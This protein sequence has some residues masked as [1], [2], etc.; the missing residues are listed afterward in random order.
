MAL[1]FIL[2]AP[3]SGRSRSL[4]E[5]CLRRAEEHPEKRYIVLVPEQFTLR[6]QRELVRLSSRGGIL[7]IDV[8]SFTRL[9]YRVF[10]QTGAAR[11]A[12]LSETGKSL[13]LRLIAA[14]EASGLSLLSGVLDRPGV[15]SEVKSILS[16][17][18]QY[19]ISA[20]D[21]D[22]MCAELRKEGGHQGLA[23]KLEEIAKLRRACETY[24]ADRFLTGEMLPRV[25][26]Q[27][28]PLD[29]TLKGCE[30]FLDSYN[31]FTPAQLEVLRVLMTIASRVTVTVTVDVRERAL[32]R[33][34]DVRAY[35]AGEFYD[36]DL[37]AV[38]KRTIRQLLEAADSAGVKTE[39]P[40]ILDDSRGRLKTG[41]AL[42]YLEEN[43]FRPGQ[44]RPFPGHAD[45][46]FLRCCADPFDEVVSAAVTVEELVRQGM[47][48]RDIAVVCGSLKEYAEYAKR[49]FTLYGIPHFIDRSSSALLNPAFEFVES[50]AAV[51]ESGFTYE[52]IMRL[53]RT[54]FAVDNEDGAA[55]VLE[56][57]LI[58]AGIRG[59]RAWQEPFAR[60]TRK[61][62]A[63]LL[64]TAENVRAAFME[65]FEPFADVMKKGKAPVRTYA[66]AV[67]NLLLAF[68]VPQKLSRMSDE[69]GEA[70][71]AVR[72]EEYAQVTGV[73]ASVLD[74]AV[75]LIGEE[76]VTRRQFAD[77]LKAGFAEAKIGVI[78]PGID[79]VHIGDFDRSRLD[80]VKVVLCLG[81][82][83]GL[84]PSRG[85]HGAVLTDMEREFLRAR[86]VQL[87]PTAREDANIQQYSVFLTFTK[88]SRALI[89]SWSSSSRKG[90]LLRPAYAVR[91][92][93]EL[94]PDCGHLTSALADP[95]R[96]VTSLRTGLGPL[97]QRLSEYL[98]ADADTAEGLEADLKELL[99]IYRQKPESAAEAVQAEP[100]PEAVQAERLLAD[101]LHARVPKDLTPEEAELLYGREIE[102]SITRLE[103][104]ARCPFRHFADYG[105]RLKER[106][107][108]ALAAPDIGSTLHKA[109]EYFAKRVSES[110]EYDWRSLPDEVRD[111]WAAECALKAAGDGGNALYEDSARSRGIKERLVR[112]VQ[113]SARTL[114]RQVRSGAFI[115]SAFE[116]SFGKDS[117]IQAAVLD[118]PGGKKMRLSGRIDRIDLSDDDGSKTLYVKV[119]DYK[120]GSKD[121]D[122]DQV[123]DG[124][125]LQLIV[126]MDAAAE[127]EA[128]AY[129]DR[130]VVCAGA[131]YYQTQDPVIDRKDS[132]GGTEEGIVSSMKVS[133]LLNSDPEVIR[134]LDGT[135]YPGGQ[136]PVIPLKLKNDGLPDSRSRSAVSAE[137]LDLL[138]GYVREKMR[139]EAGK[140]MDGSIRP[141]PVRRGTRKACDWCP[142]GDVCRFDQRAE[143]MQYREG[144]KHG[145][146]EQWEIIRGESG[147]SGPAGTGGAAGEDQQ[148]V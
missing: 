11:R 59:H 98:A 42:H 129:P 131:F 135:L 41:G 104:F 17:L 115:P 81:M 143:G 30:I 78:P 50:A 37:F 94:F 92:V 58:A 108:F 79:E 22:G 139:R 120:S 73:I 109:M 1:R 38:S 82:N 112:I 36:H 116:V 121:I 91:C 72:K 106:E 146:D 97:A 77:I 20:E 48:Y 86:K 130:K 119:V 35:A 7:N 140:M 66:E 132:A 95:M 110:R 125:Q 124:E 6:T 15:L 114:Q 33:T 62:D 4:F 67:W 111:A 13:L 123:I 60:Q 89:L 84:V 145:Q 49:V 39:E 90:E 68:E 127:L 134:R 21:L 101:A 141:N 28:A 102:G 85:K 117:R 71:D 118:L 126:Y 25:L 8:L 96:S 144:S 103:E 26:S 3:G 24:Q 99:K 122:L 148:D 56:N 2:G 9:A 80:H 14:R 12:V 128:G 61:R 76:T 29:D 74:E 16:E 70:G 138:R 100:V 32:E 93:E 45:S 23:H 53:I 75:L 52:S 54:G 47:R 136:S 142:Y 83:D 44:G 31:G 113:R 63:K 51:L 19:G 147:E 65:K 5:T 107:E 46:I 64:E 55:D 18:D 69:A 43:L 105:L 10:E 34:G 27:K 57:Y 133:G 137:R 40:V 87:A 88:P